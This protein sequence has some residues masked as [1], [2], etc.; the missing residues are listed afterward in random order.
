MK[1]YRK[2]IQKKLG[3]EL[4][5]YLLELI[6]FDKLTHKK[7]VKKQDGLIYF[8]DGFSLEYTKDLI[9]D[10]YWDRVDEDDS[11]VSDTTIK[12]ISKKLIP[13][14]TLEYG[15]FAFWLKENS[16]ADELPIVFICQNDSYMELIAT[17]TKELLRLLSSGAQRR[18]LEEEEAYHSVILEALQDYRNWLENDL[19]IKPVKTNKEID[20]IIKEAQ[21]KYQKDFFDWLS[22]N[23]SD[24]HV[25]DVY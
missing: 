19:K 17:N 5:K 7:Y 22:Q 9:E 25:K 23:G 24:T 14:A 16:T 4:P 18:M 21:D 6:H 11:T 15:Y 2:K 8:S 3:L 12:K 1:K 13:F 10:F 20:A